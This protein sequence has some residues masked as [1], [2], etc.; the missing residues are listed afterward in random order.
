M[1]RAERRR[2]GSLVQSGLLPAARHPEGDRRPG[3]G[4]YRLPHRLPSAPGKSH[5][6]AVLPSPRGKDLWDGGAGSSSGLHG[7]LLGGGHFVLAR[8]QDSERQRVLVSLHPPHPLAAVICHWRRGE[9]AGEPKL[10]HDRVRIDR[11]SFTVRVWV[12]PRYHQRKNRMCVR[13]RPPAAGAGVHA[14]GRNTQTW[15]FA[16]T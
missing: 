15:Q 11:R 14:L 16:A 7:T 6:G 10:S 5:R 12:F 13:R 4:S 1:R 9:G 3:S 2:R 8:A